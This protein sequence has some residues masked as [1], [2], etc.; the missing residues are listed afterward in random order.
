MDATV[1]VYLIKVSR[2]ARL[3]YSVLHY[4][5]QA[6]VLFNTN[7]NKRAML[8]VDQLSAGPSADPLVRGVMLVGL[9][10]Q[11]RLRSCTD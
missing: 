2:F 8:R 6:I 11:S 10:F 7:R 5:L 9:A 3:E 1:F 4:V